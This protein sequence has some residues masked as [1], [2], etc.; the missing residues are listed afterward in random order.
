MTGARFDDLQAGRGLRFG[1]PERCLVARRPEE[2]VPVLAAVAE[3]TE[4]GAWAYGYVA[5]EAAAG[6]GTGLAV[7]PPDPAGPPLVFF[8]VTGPPESVPVI[9][10]RLGDG[11]RA[12]WTPD[13]T[14]AGHR[15]AVDVVRSRIAAGETYQTNLTVRM[16]GQVAGDPAALYRDLAL[17]QRGSYNAHLDL[18]RFAVVSASPELF[19]ERRGDNVL[20]RPMKGTAARG[21]S[22]AEDLARARWLRADPKER[23]E[24]V[25]I[26]DLLRN[27]ISQVAEVGTVRAPRLLTVERYGTVLQMTSDVTATVRPG[28]G[29]VELFT[30]LFPCGS[31]TGAPKPSTMALI[32]ELEDTPRG[33]YCGAI[34]WLGPASEPV[35]ARFGVAIRTAVVDTLT[36]AAE[37]GTGSGVTWS[38][39]PAAEHREVLTK[40]SILSGR[41][42][43]HLIETMRLVPG[44]GLRNRELHLRRLAASAEELGFA[45]DR[46]HVETRLVEGLRGEGDDPRRVRLR[47]FRDGHVGIDLAPAPTWGMPL[48]VAVDDDPVDPTAWWFRHSTSWREEYRRRRLCRPD[49]DD[50]VVVDRA[51]EVVGATRATVAV[52]CDGRW[53]T[54]PLRSGCL[55]GTERARRIDAGL[56]HERVLTP[57]DLRSAEAVVLLSS[58]RGACPARV[59]PRRAPVR[60][61][62]GRGAPAR[63][64]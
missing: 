38:S 19:F 12:A 2:V 21:Q 48:T 28:T 7:T 40:T 63:G 46:E 50:V 16:R 11:Y 47:L 24:N 34:G 29:L 54:P 36:G 15:R 5:Y 3:A 51:G 41:G 43:L 56:L 22:A 6:L 55:P 1:A 62:R 31:V 39:S 27:D 26:V 57:A 35:T 37:Y 45:F 61:R 10:G 18:G 53:W 17:A 9:A 4:R 44:R 49:V 13:W 8:G 58:L 33:V 52:R 25:M 14:S 64:C 23:A 60:D 32:A 59:E 42:E 30:A 20:M